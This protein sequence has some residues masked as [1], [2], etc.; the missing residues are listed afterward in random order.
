MTRIIVIHGPTGAGKSTLAERI[1]DS[2]TK[3]C[4]LIA[5]DV[6]YNEMLNGD[7]M[8][9]KN[10]AVILI[11]LLIRRLITDG[12]NIIVEGV[13]RP[14]YFRPMFAKLNS[15]FKIDYVYLAANV[16]TSVM[17]HEGRPKQR[18]NFGE[19]KVREWHSRSESFGFNDEAI[20]E[21]DGFS[22]EDIFDKVQNSL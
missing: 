20:I 9:A 19:D 16:E 15:E 11:E 12:Y 8:E 22:A 6:I 13:L 2:T 10:E 7:G 21:T 17:R 3:P 4:A 1:R 18:H 14:D 5:Q